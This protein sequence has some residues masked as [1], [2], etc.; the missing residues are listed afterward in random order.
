[1]PQH[2]PG[3]GKQEIKKAIKEGEGYDVAL[4]TIIARGIVDPSLSV[5][6]RLHADE[7]GDEGGDDALED[8]RVAFE[9]VLVVNP[10]CVFLCDHFV[11]EEVY[12]LSLL[13]AILLLIYIYYE[14]VT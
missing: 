11:P 14:R 6:P 8:G 12:F 7:V 2:T 3:R 1:M 5:H 9:D 10:A 4:I 13:F